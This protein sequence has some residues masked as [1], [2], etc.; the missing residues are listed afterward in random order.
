MSDSGNDGDDDGAQTRRTVLQSIG[1][2]GALSLAGLGG[3]NTVRGATAENDCGEGSGLWGEKRWDYPMTV[4]TSGQTFN[5]RRSI[6]QVDVEVPDTD[7]S[8]R[9]ICGDERGIKHTFEITQ[10]ALAYGHDWAPDVSEGWLRAAANQKL[11]VQLANVGSDGSSSSSDCGRATFSVDYNCGFGLKDG[12]GLGSPKSQKPAE[13]DCSESS[14]TDADVSNIPKAV[15]TGSGVMSNYVS[16]AM[17]LAELTNV[18]SSLADSVGGSLDNI[19]TS[20]LADAFDG[21]MNALGVLDTGSTVVSILDNITK[22]QNRSYEAFT[23]NSMIINL[24]EDNLLKEWPLFDGSSFAHDLVFSACQVSVTLPPE[25]SADLQVSMDHDWE[26]QENPPNTSVPA[27]ENDVTLRIPGNTLPLSSDT[28]ITKEMVDTA[29]LRDPSRTEPLE[30]SLERTTRTDGLIDLTATVDNIDSLDNVPK[31][32]VNFYWEIREIGN[33]NTLN[34]VPP[35]YQ[36]VTEYPGTLL[37]RP[38]DVSSR[39]RSS[40]PTNA[41][42]RCTAFTRSALTPNRDDTTSESTRNALGVKVGC[43]VIDSSDPT[44]TESPTET[45]T[46]T[47]Q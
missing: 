23:G 2:I 47:S 5:L 31:S 12:D 25:T 45:T 34:S 4:T 44:T 16:R 22:H 37:T 9:P 29:R 11:D 20:L 15:L 38:V 39:M 32:D 36:E 43:L 35:I 3:F 10:M 27:P 24:Q 26:R 28:G 8:L 33:K 42:V 18:P 1:G 19:D 40:P 6:R 46:T 41:L 13:M 30:V 21:G 17:V 7:D 14:Y